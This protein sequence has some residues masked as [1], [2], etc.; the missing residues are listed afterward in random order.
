M[1]Y[2]SIIFDLDGTVVPS[3]LDG[4]PS[5]E[6]I[7]SVQKLQGKMKLSFA[8]GRSIYTCR[9]IEKVF[10][11]TDPCVIN[12]GSQIVNPKTEEV[13]WEQCLPDNVVE[14]VINISREFS[15]KF[16]INGIIFEGQANISEFPKIANIIVALGVR[17]DN[18]D[19]FVGELTKIPDLAV[20]ILP[21]WIEGDY[22]DIHITHKLATKKYA[23]EKLIEI[24][25]V[26]KEEVIGIGDGN[27]DIA[28]FESV[29]YKVA[30]GNAVD[31]LKNAAD[32]I[33]DTLENHGF[34]KFIEEKLSTI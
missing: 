18:T 6:V 32:Y 13:L 31:V 14:N 2:K 30:M 21:S 5:E 9:D 22:W 23:I 28:L 26:K 24:L 8:T 7:K 4:M 20:H 29:G 3:K 15:E 11:L 19:Y 33:T 17:K 27:N 16:I 10:N 25:G 1:K 34:A 12:G